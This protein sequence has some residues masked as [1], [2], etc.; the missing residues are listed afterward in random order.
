MLPYI[1]LEIF[2]II[3]GHPNHF[4]GQRRRATKEK[5]GCVLKSSI[6][7][8][9]EHNSTGN[10]A[11][12]IITPTANVQAIRNPKLTANCANKDKILGLSV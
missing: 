10:F 9:E 3:A 8:Y 4:T 12:Y 11:T 6:N 7:C 1:G 5:M 2:D